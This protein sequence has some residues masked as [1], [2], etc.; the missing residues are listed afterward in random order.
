MVGITYG[1]SSSIVNQRLMD[2]NG[3]GWRGYNK[4]DKKVKE[5]HIMEEEN[6]Q[7]RKFY[8]EEFKKQ[9]CR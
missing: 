5:L 2:I 1:S 9:M 6:M 8:T 4:L 3:D 7:Q